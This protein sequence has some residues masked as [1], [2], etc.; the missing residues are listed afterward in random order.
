MAD[1]VVLGAGL[2]GANIAVDLSHDHTVT[3]VDVH[4]DRL[5]AVKSRGDIRCLQMDISDKRALQTLVTRYDLVV[6]A[7]PGF[8]GFETVKAVIQTGINMVDISFFPEN[9]L[10]L[11]DLAKKHN[12]TI[13]VDCGIAP[14]MSNLFLGHFSKTMEIDDF[15]CYVGGLPTIRVKPF[16]YKAPFSPVDVIEE[17]TRPCRLKENGKLVIK[18][19]L[20]DPEFIEFDHVGTLEAFNTDGLRTLLDTVPVANMREKTLRYVGH[21]ELMLILRDSGFFSQEH[22]NIRG[23]SMRPL[24]L[25]S[26]LLTTAWAME[27]EE[28][29]IT[30]MRICLSGTK[31][32][33]RWAIRYD[34]FDRYDPVTHTS[35]MA[36]TTG[37]TCAAVANILVNNEYQ[38]V[39]VN[40]PELIGMDETCFTNIIT[41]LE[42]RNIHFVQSVTHGEKETQTY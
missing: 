17:Y 22:L 15:V 9:A 32:E 28:P 31:A 27:S 39:G 21:R 3:A 7:V 2:V 14:G 37:Y 13:A 24:D 42:Q 20:S 38:R 36:R 1:I 16:E 11:D 25:T 18:P 30:V 41:Y 23:Q 4:Q 35:S 10:D 12:V 8:M 34:L 19:A 5:N 6:G 26:H 33:E 29:D 40:P